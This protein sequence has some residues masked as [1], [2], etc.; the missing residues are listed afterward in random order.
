MKGAH[1]GAPFSNVSFQKPSGVHD[2]K[3]IY[4]EALRPS[5]PVNYLLKSC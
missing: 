3:N 1:E 4:L 2:L 5:M